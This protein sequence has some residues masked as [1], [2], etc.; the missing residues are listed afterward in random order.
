M[1]DSY[2][3]VAIRSSRDAMVMTL[4]HSRIGSEKQ[5]PGCN[6]HVSDRWR[7]SADGSGRCSRVRT[8]FEL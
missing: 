4:G 8:D 6:C 3:A 1:S 5:A 7:I 2:R